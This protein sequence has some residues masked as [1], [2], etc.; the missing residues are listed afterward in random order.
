MDNFKIDNVMKAEFKNVMASPAKGAQ[1]IKKRKGFLMFRVLSGIMTSL[2]ALP[3][4]YAQA[5]YTENVGSRACIGYA[6]LAEAVRYVEMRKDLAERM[7]QTEKLNLRDMERVMLRAK[8]GAGASMA[9]AAIAVSAIAMIAA[10]PAA[11]ATASGAAISTLAGI[12]SV[13]DTSIYALT[14]GAGGI[15][16]GF[17]GRWD[18]AAYPDFDAYRR[19]RYSEVSP[20]LLARTALAY[21]SLFPKTHSEINRLH[22]ENVEKIDAQALGITV[23]G[24]RIVFDLGTSDL[25]VVGENIASIKTHLA[26]WT[27]ELYEAEAAIENMAVDCE[28]WNLN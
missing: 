13:V 1:K 16:I 27:A 5:T 26:L 24:Y 6:P 14:S 21:F 4:A 17:T 8:I 10:V 20:D 7:V 3:T 15:L 25:K 2:Y 23:L 9:S 12:G 28:Y 22:K 19:K 18:P 11:T